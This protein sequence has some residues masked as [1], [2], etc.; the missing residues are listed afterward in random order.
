VFLLKETLMEYI[1]ISHYYEHPDAEDILSKS[2]TSALELPVRT[3]WCV[4]FSPT[5]KISAPQVKTISAASRSPNICLQT[6]PISE[7]C[8][9]TVRYTEHEAI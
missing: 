3:T 8:G 9:S 6:R 4:T 1:P 5:F 7:C 2:D